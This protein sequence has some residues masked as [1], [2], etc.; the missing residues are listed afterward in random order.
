MLP[1]IATAKRCHTSS[2]L[3]LHKLGSN[4]SFIKKCDQTNLC[5]VYSGLITFKIRSPSL[6]PPNKSFQFKTSNPK[7][8]TSSFIYAMCK[9]FHF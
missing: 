5:L 2:G 7:V 9:Y 3:T 6:S 4:L 8:F 1:K